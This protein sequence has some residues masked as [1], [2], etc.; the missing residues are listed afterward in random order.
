MNSHALV[1]AMCDFMALLDFMCG[2]F[3]EGIQDAH[4][5]VA[6]RH[7]FKLPEVEAST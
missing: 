6:E 7:G 5:R 2:D 3:P 1:D 4:R